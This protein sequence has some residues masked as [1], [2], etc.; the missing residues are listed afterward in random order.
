M[1]LVLQRKQPREGREPLKKPGNKGGRMNRD[2]FHEV[3]SHFRRGGCRI[4][5][6][7]ETEPTCLTAHHLNPKTKLFNVGRNRNKFSREMVE[8]ELAKCVP[9]CLNCHAKINAGV[10]DEHEIQK[11]T[12]A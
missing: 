8:A 6:C 5:G 2:E 9:V 3:I 7:G 1:N 10:L 4:R 11:R 12:G